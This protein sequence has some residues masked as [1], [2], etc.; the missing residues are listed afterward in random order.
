MGI[1]PRAAALPIRPTSA[2]ELQPTLS[3]CPAPTSPTAAP[4]EAPR[5]PQTHPMWLVLRLIS[6][7]RSTLV[8]S[9]TLLRNFCGHSGA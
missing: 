4:P 1:R 6:N 7:S 3:S 5:P 9:C 8:D 2:L